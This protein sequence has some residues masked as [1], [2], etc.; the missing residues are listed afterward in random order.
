M[1][2]NNICINC[3]LIILLF[4]LSSINSNQKTNGEILFNINCAQC[5][6]INIEIVGPALANISTRYKNRWILKY[7]KNARQLISDNDTIAIALFEKYKIE[8]PIFE[9]ELSD[10]EIREIIEFIKIKSK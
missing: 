10:K 2:I 5:H 7:I 9:N 1:K 8:H 6:A 3:I 4:F